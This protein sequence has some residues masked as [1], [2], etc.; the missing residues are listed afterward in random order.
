MS[1]TLLAEIES[2]SAPPSLPPVLD[3]IFGGF[4][5]WA[6]HPAALFGLLLLLNT[7]FRPYL[8]I[9]H[10]AMLYSGQ[11]LSRLDPAT[12]SDDLFFRYGSQDRF[13]IFSPL[14]AP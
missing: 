4:R 7:L 13:S 8:G 6:A 5:R 10:D 9:H 12:Y 14:M 11:V 1:S 3:A 2:P